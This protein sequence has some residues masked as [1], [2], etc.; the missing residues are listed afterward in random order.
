LAGGLDTFTTSD[1]NYARY[2]KEIILETLTGGDKGERMYRHYLYDESCGKFMNTLFLL[3]LRKAKALE[4]FRLVTPIQGFTYI[5]L[6][7]RPVD[8]IYV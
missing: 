8:G 3:A 2:L 7:D 5:M 6:I 1:Y 4:T